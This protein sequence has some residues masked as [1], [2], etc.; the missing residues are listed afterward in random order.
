MAFSCLATNAFAKEANH[1]SLFFPIAK[2]DFFLINMASPKIATV[3]QLNAWTYPR[4]YSKNVR[5]IESTILTKNDGE[6]FGWVG[7][8]TANKTSASVAQHVMDLGTSPVPALRL[9]DSI[10]GCDE[11]QES[12]IS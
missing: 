2:V 7:P 9:Q 1:V 6:G 12:R 5:K 3:E 8:E 11:C 10:F 4:H